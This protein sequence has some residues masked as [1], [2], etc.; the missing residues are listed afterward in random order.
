MS[1][2][3]A[4]WLVP[5][6]FVTTDNSGAITASA[7][8]YNALLLGEMLSSGSAV[9]DEAVLVKDYKTAKELFGERSYL[10]KMVKQFK[11]IDTTTPLYVIP[12]VEAVGSAQATGTITVAG[13]AVANSTLALTIDG[14]D[15]SI[16]CLQGDTDEEIATTI[17]DTVSADTEAIV[18]ASV[19]GAVVT[20]TAATAGSVGNQISIKMNQSPLDETPEGVTVTIVAMSGGLLE[21]DATQAIVTMGSTWYQTIGMPYTSTANLDLFAVEMNSRWG[22]LKG[23]G[24]MVFDAISLLTLSDYITKM[25][26][27]NDPFNCMQQA[28]KLNGS[29]TELIAETVATVA[30]NGAKDP[31]KPFTFLPLSVKPAGINEEFDAEDRNILLNAGFATNT[32]TESRSSVIEYLRTTYTKTDADVNDI[33]YRNVNTILTLIRMSYDIKAKFNSYAGYKLAGSGGSVSGNQLI[34]TKSLASSILVSLNQDWITAGIAEDS[35]A[36]KDGL[37]VEVNPN[38]PDGL[39]ISITPDLMNQFR[40]A[41]VTNLYS[42]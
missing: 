17:G 38:N 20:I 4:N 10:A 33:S 15:Y 22:A 32:S 40:S 19:T 23:L 36:F 2:L 29:V 6:A 1:D 24:G 37:V 12:Q 11:V 9:K 26:T 41:D 28:H 35:D 42:L 13:A 27:L 25:S 5:L 18:T 8:S 31:A 16:P 30:L 14:V 34:M 21:A 39:T 3:P 7:L